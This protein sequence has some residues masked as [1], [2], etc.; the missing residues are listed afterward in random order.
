MT[1][2][3]IT[4]YAFRARMLTIPKRNP[5]RVKS[6]GV[7]YGKKTFLT[8]DEDNK[9]QSPQFFKQSLKKLRALSKALSRK[10][11]GSGNYY[12]ACRALEAHAPKGYYKP[13][14]IVLT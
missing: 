7:D 2:A 11:K 13:F 10:V 1:G 6:A 14:Y 3:V 12:R 4:G 8:S 5:R 9:I